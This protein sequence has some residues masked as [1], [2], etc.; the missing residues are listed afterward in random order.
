M[1]S[2][3][4]DGQSEHEKAFCMPVRVLKGLSANYDLQAVCSRVLLYNSPNIEGGPN[5]AKDI[6]LFRKTL[7]I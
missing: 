7:L 6:Y 5:K 2:N 4:E 3:K 1:A